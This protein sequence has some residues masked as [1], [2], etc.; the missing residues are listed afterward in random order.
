MTRLDPDVAPLT[1]TL[2]SLSLS[3]SLIQRARLHV[4]R[5]HVLSALTLVYHVGPY[6]MLWQNREI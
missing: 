4:H 3:Q 2:C 6:R 5:Y 1:N